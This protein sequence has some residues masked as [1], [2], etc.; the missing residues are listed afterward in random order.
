MN[1]RCDVYVY[2]SVSGYWTTHVAGR[3]RII[4]PIPGLP[5][6]RF[7]FGGT[8]DQVTRQME[9]PNWRKKLAARI[10]FGFWTFWE[11]RV[12]MASLKLIPLRDIGGRYDGETFNDATAQDCADRLIWLRAEGYTV[13]DYA[14]DALREEGEDEE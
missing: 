3:K 7:N 4:P 9:Y 10:V 6:P 1:W 5:L 8:W 11:N 14:I 2:E 12:H 13:P